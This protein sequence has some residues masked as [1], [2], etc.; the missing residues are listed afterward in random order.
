MQRIWE[1]IDLVPQPSWKNK[2]ITLSWGVQMGGGGGGGVGRTPHIFLRTVACKKK[3]AE[4]PDI[5]ALLYSGIDWCAS[6]QLCESK[7]N[8]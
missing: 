3:Y 6:Q 2:F 7:A 1:H 8:S 5:P 4:R